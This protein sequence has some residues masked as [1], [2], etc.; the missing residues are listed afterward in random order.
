MTLKRPVGVQVKVLRLAANQ[1]A[2]EGAP[3][4]LRT[5][6]EASVTQNRILT[7]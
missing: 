4:E 7:C 2:S 5:W 6:F 1:N 3:K